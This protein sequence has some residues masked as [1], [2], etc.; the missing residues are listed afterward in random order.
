[1]ANEHVFDASTDT[2]TLVGDN[3]TGTSGAGV[4]RTGFNGA[5]SATNNKNIVRFSM[6]M[7]FGLTGNTFEAGAAAISLGTAN[8]ADSYNNSTSFSRVQLDYDANNDVNGVGVTL[9]DGVN[10]SSP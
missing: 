1:G 10:G 8:N 7:L 3:V 9:T 2:L 4:T 6:T 5:T